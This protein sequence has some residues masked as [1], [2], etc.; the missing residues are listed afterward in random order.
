MKSVKICIQSIEI[1]KFQGQSIGHEVKIL[2]KDSAE[3]VFVKKPKAGDKNIKCYYSPP[4]NGKEREICVDYVLVDKE[5]CFIWATK[6]C[7]LILKTF[8]PFYPFERQR[9]AKWKD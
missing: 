1:E 3:L 9:V 7:S 6:K 5:H 8:L 4:I 2:K